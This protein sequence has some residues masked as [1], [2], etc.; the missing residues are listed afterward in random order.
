MSVEQIDGF[1]DQSV[2]ILESQSSLVKRFSFG[3]VVLRNFAESDVNEKYNC[4][5]RKM[6]GYSG[7]SKSSLFMMVFDSCF[8]NQTK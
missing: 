6:A 2:Y 3:R 1:P 8:A 4:D 7:I 5:P